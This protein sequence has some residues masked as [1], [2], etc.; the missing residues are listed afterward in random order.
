MIDLR[1][2]TVTRPSKAMLE[3][4]MAAPTGDDV[5]GDDPTVNELQAYA[6]KISGK[7]AALFLPTG[8]QANLVALLSHCE[9]GEEYIVGQLAHNYLYEAGGA[10]VLG[11]IQPQPIEA[12]QDG[13]LPLDKVAAKIKPDDIHFARTKLL[14]LE[15]THNGKVL[16]REYLQQAWE[17]TRKHNLALHVDGARIFNAVVAYDCQL[18]E[19]VRY[20]DSFTICLSKGLGTPVGSLLVGSHDYIKRATRWRKMVGGGMRQAGILAAAGLYALEN[21]V[22]RLRE[23]HENAH[24]LAGE[25]REIGVD[26]TRQ[27]T[28]MV[29]VRVPVEQAESLG[30]Y[31][32]ERGVLMSAGPITRL[33]THLDV[34]REQLAEVVSHWRAFTQQ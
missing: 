15:N 5:Y 14:S 34:S 11:S 31:M 19:I 24:W 27:D 10:A 28:N 6:A 9:R 13:S 3:K 29:F 30:K 26:V 16:P 25:L 22:Q 18:E 21:N 12:N 33:V 20:C 4:M 32:R 8:T 23:D 1:S 7:E 2:D 17:F